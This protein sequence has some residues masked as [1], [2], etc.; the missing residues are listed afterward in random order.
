M[1]FNPDN[2]NSMTICGHVYVL[3]EKVGGITKVLSVHD[4]YVKISDTSNKFVVGPVPYFKKSNHSFPHPI[5]VP[6]DPKEDPLKDMDKL[7]QN[8]YN[9]PPM[10]KIDN[11]TNN[12]L[13]DDFGFK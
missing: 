3:C 8:K 11:F 13:N 10:D 9:F 4:E 5:T 12:G 2:F 1:Q 7:K 6:I